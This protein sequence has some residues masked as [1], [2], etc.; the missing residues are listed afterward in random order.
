MLFNGC[1]NYQISLSTAMLRAFLDDKNEI[2][3][4]KTIKNNFLL[5]FCVCFVDWNLGREALQSG[6]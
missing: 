6:L 5:L 3:T 1:A 2:K 4:A